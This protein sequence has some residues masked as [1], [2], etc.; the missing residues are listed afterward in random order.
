MPS[1][2]C[3]SINDPCPQGIPKASCVSYTGGNL[4]CIGVETNDRLD[5]ILGKLNDL[6]CDQSSVLEF[7]NWLTKTDNLVQFGGTL[8]KDTLIDFVTYDL[9]TENLLSDNSIT[10]YLG[11]DSI[12]RV[13][14]TN[15]STILSNV[16]ADNGLNKS[17]DVTVEL[18]GLLLHDTQIDFGDSNLGL[19]SVIEDETTTQ[20]LALDA[21]GN[22]KWKSVPSG[23]SFLTSAINGLHEDT[24]NEVRLGGPLI[25]NTQV[26]W[27]GYSMTWGQQGFN[28]FSYVPNTDDPTQ[29]GTLRT[30]FRNLDTLPNYIGSSIYQVNN[31]IAFNVSYQTTPNIANGNVGISY[32]VSETQSQITGQVAHAG[33]GKI[34]FINRDVLATTVGSSTEYVIDAGNSSASIEMFTS[35]PDNPGENNAII[36][37]RT[38]N[39]NDDGSDKGIII[40]PT[41]DVR[42]ENYL[43]SRTDG[44]TSKA[45][46]VD[47]SGNILYGTISPGAG[48]TAVSHTDTNSI[49]WTGDGSGGSPLTA[50]VKI[51]ATAGNQAV[52]NGDGVFVPSYTPPGGTLGGSLGLL[53]DVIPRSNGTG[54]AT[55]QSSLLKI[56]NS[57]NISPITNDIGALGTTALKWA[58]LFLASGSVINW[59]SG[60]LTLT[61]SANTLTLAG[62]S[63]NL[64]PLT[65]SK[66]LALDAS[67]NIVSS[68]FGP[69]DIFNWAINTQAGSY[70]AVLGDGLNNTLVRMN[71]NIANNFTVPANATVAFPIGTPLTVVQ[72]GT[73]QTNILAAVGVTILSYLS[74]THIIGQNGAISLIKVAT[75]TWQLMGDLA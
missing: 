54:G 51:S 1:N 8:V 69:T 30:L 18:G 6:L 62:G 45:L 24:P 14:Q 3:Q 29:P 10:Q 39:T 66:F 5:V 50:T 41:S 63:L 48:L 2:C 33:A 35:D 11:L 20:L 70:A 25:E 23:A 75:N 15:V 21:N 43:S 16:L 40:L 61:H 72:I 36:R 44:S 56:D 13:R 32:T 9:Y 26:D 7:N 12:G 17:D 28:E 46:Y 60:D 65:A 53:G 71:S 37:L 64:S 68:T 38:S 55:F 59:N 22:V 74:Q 58:D 42:F 34:V 4:T 47:A 67:K 73:G 27:T 49:S 57:G 19:I 52:I 31:D